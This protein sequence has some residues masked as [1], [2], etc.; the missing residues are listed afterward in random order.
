V[1][2]GQ[3]DE[4]DPRRMLPQLAGGHRAQPHPVTF[5]STLSKLRL[6]FF[7]MFARARERTRDLLISYIFSFHHFTA[8][9]QRSPHCGFVFWTF[10]DTRS[11]SNDRELK[12]RR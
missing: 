3:D 4:G 6:R 11:Q 10:V 7:F 2:G 9:P 8:E 5:V 12:R 1:E